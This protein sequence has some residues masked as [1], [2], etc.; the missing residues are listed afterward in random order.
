MN[1]PRFI[2]Q[3][4]AGYPSLVPSSRQKERIS[5]SV[6]DRLHNH[7]EVAIFFQPESEERARRHAEKLNEE[8]DDDGA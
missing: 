3:R 6:Y 8:W 5:W 4:L 2:V 7:M 1:E